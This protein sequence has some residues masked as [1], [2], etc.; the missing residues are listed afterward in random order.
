MMLRLRPGSNN[1]FD[2]A[3]IKVTDGIVRFGSTVIGDL[4]DGNPLRIRI[5]LTNDNAGLAAGLAATGDTT[6]NTYKSSIAASVYVNGESTPKTSCDFSTFIT[7]GDSFT[8]PKITTQVSDA[9][10]KTVRR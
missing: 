8:T 7:F 6:A 9:A 4:N 2:L 3:I 10:V 1:K 5:L